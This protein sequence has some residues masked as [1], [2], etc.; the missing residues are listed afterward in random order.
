[1]KPTKPSRINYRGLC[2]LALYLCLLPMVAHATMINT[3]ND[4]LEYITGTV[5]KTIAMLAVV[6]V[7]FG[8]LFLGKVSKGQAVGT[9]VAVGLI[10]GAKAI[11]G[12]LTA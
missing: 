11:V 10:F 1:M 12:M 3:L 5:G 2:Y 8:C 7:G 6:G 9:V 4:G